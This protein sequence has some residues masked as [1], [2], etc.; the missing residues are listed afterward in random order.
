MAST[1]RNVWHLSDIVATEHWS[2]TF[3]LHCPGLAST[4]ERMRDSTKS[5]ILV[6]EPSTTIAV[7]GATHSPAA[8]EDLPEA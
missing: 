8:E 1:S 7:S 3:S 5:P 6:G 4:G 2:T